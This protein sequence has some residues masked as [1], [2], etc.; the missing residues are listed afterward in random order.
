VP[1]LGSAVGAASSFVT[2]WALGKVA[3]K[4]FAGD[5]SLSA[6]DL[7]L[8]YAQAQKD[9]MTAYETSRHAVTH[10]LGKH[11]GHDD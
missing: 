4:Y 8:L 1:F 7:R 11:S 3:N 6:S 5:G 10:A 9:A 2:T